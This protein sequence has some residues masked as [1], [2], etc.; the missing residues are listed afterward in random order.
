MGVGRHLCREVVMDIG[1]HGHVFIIRQIIVGDQVALLVLDWVQIFIPY[2]KCL[3]KRFDQRRVGFAEARALLRCRLGKFV[4]PVPVVIGA[5]MLR[6]HLAP[7]LPLVIRAL[8]PRLV[9]GQ[10]LEPRV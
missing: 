4:D 5:R 6:Q 2:T 3:L 9:F 10:R 8:F 1:A 7:A